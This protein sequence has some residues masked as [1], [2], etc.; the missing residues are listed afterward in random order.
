MAQHFRLSAAALTLDP[1]EISRMSDKQA[2]AKF[3]EIR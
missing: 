1:S 2:H 3:V